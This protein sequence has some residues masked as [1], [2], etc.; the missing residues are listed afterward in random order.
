MS[1]YQLTIKIANSFVSGDAIP[2]AFITLS[3]PGLTNPVTAGFYPQPLAKGVSIELKS[4]L[5]R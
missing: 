3:G 1:N 2:H 5:S 4:D